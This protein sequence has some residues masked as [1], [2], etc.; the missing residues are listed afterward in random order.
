MGSG[1]VSLIFLCGLPTKRPLPQLEILVGHRGLTAC[2]YC[3]AREVSASPRLVVGEAH[4]TV[5]PF[6]VAWA[7]CAAAAVRC[8]PSSPPPLAGFAGSAAGHPHSHTQSLGFVRHYAVHAFTHFN[9]FQMTA[10]PQ[11]RA[12]ESKRRP[13]NPRRVASQTEGNTSNMVSRGSAERFLS[14]HAALRQR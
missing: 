11:C 8:A 14:M 4:L 7:A 2:C 5:G 3:K 12:R 13:R 10:P 1:T 6:A 9:Y